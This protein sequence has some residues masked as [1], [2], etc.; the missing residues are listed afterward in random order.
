MLTRHQYMMLK[1]LNDGV[2]DDTAKYLI[3]ITAAKH[4]EW[5]MNESKSLEEWDEEYY[6]SMGKEIGGGPENNPHMGWSHFQRLRDTY[7]KV[8]RRLVS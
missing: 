1:L 8:W 3:A 2:A 5:D 4:P 7:S 6:G